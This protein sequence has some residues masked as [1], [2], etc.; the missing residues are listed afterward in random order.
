MMKFSFQRPQRTHYSVIRHSDF[1][2]KNTKNGEGKNIA[3]LNYVYPHKRTSAER[4]RKLF[5]HLYI[6]FFFFSHTLDNTSLAHLNRHQHTITTFCFT[7]F[8]SLVSFLKLGVVSCSSSFYLA[9]MV[10]NVEAFR[11]PGVALTK[12][13]IEKGLGD[14][15]WR[16]RGEEKPYFTKAPFTHSKTHFCKFSQNI[17]FFK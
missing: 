6:N 5:S 14:R 9:A 11:P 17:S 15:L 13:S 4:H 10:N 7:F 12:D 2:E 3:Y 16:V 1:P 8:P